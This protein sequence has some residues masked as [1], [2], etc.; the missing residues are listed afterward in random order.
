LGGYITKHRKE[1]GL[2]I[3]EFAKK[4]GIYEFTLIKWEG[5]KRLPHP[6]Y[7]NNLKRVIPGLAAVAKDS[8]SN[9]R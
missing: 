8:Y 6:R 3:R 2:L 9:V 7:L 1:K 4:L 5:G